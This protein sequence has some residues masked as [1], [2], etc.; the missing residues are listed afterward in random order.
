MEHIELKG[1]IFTPSPLASRLWHIYIKTE[2]STEEIVF[3]VTVI[4]KFLI[5]GHKN[6]SR[7][8]YNW[9]E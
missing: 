1:T 3:I 7:D 8:K 6:N 2:K 4:I 9:Q 5:V